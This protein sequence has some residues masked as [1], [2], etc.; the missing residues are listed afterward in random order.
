MKRDITGS[1]KDQVSAPSYKR[2]FFLN[3]LA[4]FSRR[5][6]LMAFNMICARLLS[7]HAFTA[8]G[9]FRIAINTIGLMAGK[10]VDNGVVVTISNRLHNQRIG[11]T[12]LAA[13][14]LSL[15]LAVAAFGLIML[16]PGIMGDNGQDILRW[17]ILILIVGIVASI[18]LIFSGAIQAVKDFATLA[19]VAIGFGVVLLCLGTPMAFVFSTSGAIGAISCLFI[20]E[21]LVLLFI[22]IVQ[23]KRR[24]T[25][26]AGLL[27]SLKELLH[28]V[29]AMSFTIIVTRLSMWLAYTFVLNLPDGSTRGGEFYVAWSIFAIATVLPGQLSRT[30]LPYLSDVKAQ[31]S[32]KFALIAVSHIRHVVFLAAIIL[33][34]LATVMPLFLRLTFGE[35]FVR[36]SSAASL[37]LGGGMLICFSGMV[38]QILISRRN[39]LLY[40]LANCSAGPIY[41]LLAWLLTP[42]LGL[43][44]QAG[45]LAVSRIAPTLISFIYL[46]HLCHG[47]A[48]RR[49]MVVTIVLVFSTGITCLLALPEGLLARLA[50]GLP[51][52]LLLLLVFWKSRSPG[53]Q[54]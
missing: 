40:V 49:L 36:V 21:A 44:G 38:N 43:E 24:K 23:A 5:G 47:P 2:G 3:A 32:P 37:M 19:K 26:E 16:A 45:A 52:I 13:V 34:G 53:P 18:S 31:Q 4:T 25:V 22:V 6:A 27:A 11:K 1:S 15:V 42:R 29:G 33:V 41:V 28:F 8:Y 30:S 14:I 10:C 9:T 48:F 7:E 39:M 54:H 51:S 35:R 20:L 12:L 46:C 50:I 17:P